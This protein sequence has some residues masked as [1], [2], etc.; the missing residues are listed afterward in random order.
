MDGVAWVAITHV[1]SVMPPHTA[2]QQ[3]HIILGSVL[4][5]GKATMTLKLHIRH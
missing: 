1:S 5:V 2:G 4:I 3:K